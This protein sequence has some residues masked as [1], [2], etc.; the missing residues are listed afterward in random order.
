MAE[1]LNYEEE[2]SKCYGEDGKV[3]NI[4]PVV[5]LIKLSNAE[6]QA[7][8]VNYGRLY[9][10]QS[11]KTVCPSDWHLPSNEE[12]KILITSVGGE[13]TAGKFLKAKSGWDK[14]GNGEDK[15]GF[16]ALPSGR[17]CGPFFG[18]AGKY[19]GWWN[20][21]DNINKHLSYDSNMIHDSEKSESFLIKINKDNLLSVRC[22][23]D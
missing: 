19:G 20:A 1:N 15:F 9:N 14:N 7:N 18:D 5:N 4:K 8:C 17:R 6:I 10:W 21:S 11:A 2:G 3:N 13:K 16:A 23:Q 22:V 12:W